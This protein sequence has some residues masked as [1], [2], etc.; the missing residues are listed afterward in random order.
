MKDRR[1]ASGMSADG[2]YRSI[3]ADSERDP[4]IIG[5][6]LAGSRGKGFT[7]AYSDY[8]VDMI[9]EDKC[10]EEYKKKYEGQDELGVDVG[11]FDLAGFRDYAAIRT[12][13]AWDRYSF[14]HVKAVVDKKN[15]GI[16]KLVDEKGSLSASEIPK[17]IWDACD[18][19]LNQFYRAL[20]C[21]RDGDREAAKLEL[22]ESVKPLL[23]A[24][25]ALHGRVKP[26]YKYLKWELENYPLTLFPWNSAELQSIVHEL[27]T[28]L[29]EAL[30]RDV[31]RKT[32]EV[33]RRH[34]H[35]AV[36]D[37]WGDKLHTL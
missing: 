22:A 8:D 7:T 32:E 11:V 2:L 29:D 26:Y 10:L 15:G 25:F 35:G 4:N 6:V 24:M 13:S 20:K 33:F 30:I 34:G 37:S 3:V 14:T 9:V 21:A 16:Q 19:Y 12:E 17:V 27:S 1:S 5:L 18:F 28:G 36:F 23:E 31:I